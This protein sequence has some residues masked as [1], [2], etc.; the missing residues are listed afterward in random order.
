MTHWAICCL[1]LV[2][3]A[4]RLPSV[5]PPLAHT[6][7]STDILPDSIEEEHE[8]EEERRNEKGQ[9]KYL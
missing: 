5:S 4:T 3:R 8:Q 9:Y 2:L 7:I 1:Q 6:C